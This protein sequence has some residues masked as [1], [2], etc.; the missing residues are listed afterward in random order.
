LR[1]LIKARRFVL[2]N[3]KKPFV[4][5]VAFDYRKSGAYRRCLLNDLARA[6]TDSMALLFGAGRV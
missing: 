2:N 4:G 1:R 6:A 5:F 3:L